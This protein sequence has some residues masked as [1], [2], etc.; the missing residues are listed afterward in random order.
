MKQ[1]IAIARALAFDPDVLLMDEPFAALDEQARNGLHVELIRIWEQTGKTIVFVTHSIE[2]AVF[3]SDRIA[4]LSSAPAVMREVIDIDI[5]RP[6]TLETKSS[7]SFGRH[8]TNIWRLL[9][10]SEERT[11]EDVDETGRRILT[12]VPQETMI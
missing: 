11:K 8:R 9:Q 10:S 1:R 2:E 7:E 3:L 6:R 5:E 4:L 12:T